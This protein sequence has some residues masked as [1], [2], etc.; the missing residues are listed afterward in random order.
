MINN[1]FYNIVQN[2]QLIRNRYNKLYLFL[3]IFTIILLVAGFFI[4]QNLKLEV[5]VQTLENISDL[6]SAT[7][8]QVII[9]LITPTSPPIIPPNKLNPFFFLL[10]LTSVLNL[11]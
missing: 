4:V 7:I 3:F 9:D 5:D 2:N 1:Q 11:S 6:G 8:S 10:E